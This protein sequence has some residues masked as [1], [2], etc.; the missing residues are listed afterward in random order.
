MSITDKIKTRAFEL[1][2]DL[3]GVSP[4]QPAKT[5]NFYADW[6]ERGFAGEMS[7]LHRH[8]EKKRDPRRLLPGA[9]SIISFGMNYFTFNIPE[10]IKRDASRGIISRY[11]W[12]TDY[13]DIIHRKLKRLFWFIKAEVN[14]EIYGKA[15]VD[16]APIFEREAAN[17]SGIG[18][19]GKNSNLI[20]PK[21]GSWLFLAEILVDI[22]LEYDKPLSKN[23]CGK[24]TRCLDACP[25]GALVAPYTLDAS[26]CISYL[27]IELKGSI[28]SELRPLMGNHIFG[29]DI[30]Q[31][32]C[33]WNRK[34]KPTNEHSFWPKAGDKFAASQFA[35]SVVAPDL[36]SLM[37]L[38]EAEFRV[39][40]KDSP[41]KRTKRRGFL[42]NVAVAL[43]NWRYRE[44][45]SPPPS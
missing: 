4:A 2:F 3:V 19:I 18:F 11:A 36:L 16:T 34:A 25:T 30:C 9:R 33:P 14:R 40:F 26:R 29:C 1:G 37:E 5:T 41:I 24:C 32:V 23:G 31:D 39:R 21:L 15:Y 20:N 38:S 17:N 10:E 8:L 22:E 13:H 45:K 35:Y 43:D 28:P 7:Y 44:H 27:T 42:R 12:G 6:L